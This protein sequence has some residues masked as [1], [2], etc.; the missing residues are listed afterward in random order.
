MATYSV[1]VPKEIKKNESRVALTPEGVHELVSHGVSVFVE[2]SAGQNAN[3][4]DSEYTQA[5]A[6]ICDADKAWSSDIVVK[7]KEPQ[8]SEFKYF[9]DDLILFT[10]LHLAAYPG[11][12]KALCDARTTSIAYETVSINGTLP[13]LAPMSE[14]AGR[15]AVQV[16]MRFLERPQGGKGMLLSGAPGVPPAK[17]CVLG[18]GNVGLN[19]ALLAS[20]LGAQVELFDINLEKLRAIDLMFHGQFVTRASSK[21]SIAQSVRDSDVVIGAVLIPGGRAPVVV[22]KEMISTMKPGSVVVDTAIDQGGCIETSHETS[23]SE[24]TYMVDDVVHYAVG[25]M[26]GSVG[27]TSTYALTNATLSYIV[28]LA[29]QSLN[30]AL[31]KT[32]GLAEGL[33]TREGEIVNQS[34]REAVKF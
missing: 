9:R 31:E 16:A 34:V 5:G 18:A 26:P 7:V 1:G 6:Q 10:Y 24:P 25:N 30:V 22:S 4:S 14:I 20:K 27:N 23:H 3:I 2:M 33:N 12:A 29:T 28:A 8:T 13:L 17:V 15:L 32:P 11:V 21:A 19:S